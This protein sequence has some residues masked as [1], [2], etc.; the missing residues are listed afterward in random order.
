MIV[1]TRVSWEKR[2]VGAVTVPPARVIPKDTH[3]V[4][5]QDAHLDVNATRYE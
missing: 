2:E 5:Q 3:A 4:S 1:K